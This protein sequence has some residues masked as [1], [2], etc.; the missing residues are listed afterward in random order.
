MRPAMPER[1]VSGQLARWTRAAGQKK[2]ALDPH[3]WAW[4]RWW[5]VRVHARGRD[6]AR[7]DLGALP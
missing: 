5:E 3:A 2:W 1:P 6:T 4:G 7:G